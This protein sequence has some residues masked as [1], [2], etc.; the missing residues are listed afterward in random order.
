MSEPDTELLM[1]TISVVAKYDRD[2]ERAV[3]VLRDWSELR[4]QDDPG[5]TGND[6]KIPVEGERRAPVPDVEPDDE[7]TGAA[8]R[9]ARDT[10][11]RH[12]AGYF[13]ENTDTRAPRRPVSS[14]QGE[15]S[16]AANHGRGKR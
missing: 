5:R 8:L 11:G 9:A 6:R 12:G 10:P 14:S 4:E 1:D 16:F 15:R 2:V 13:G 3:R 7:G